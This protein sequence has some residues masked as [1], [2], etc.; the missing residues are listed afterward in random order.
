MTQ[1]PLPASALAENHEADAA[2]DDGVR[3]I[4]PDVAY[5]QLAIVN[6][7]FYGEAG[8]GD[9]GWVL[10]DAGV[11]GS[12]PAI[13]HAAQARFG[14]SGRPACIVLTHGHFDHVGVL[15]TLSREWDVPV[16]AHPLEHPYLNGTRSYP[17]PDPHVGGGMLARLSPL[18]PTSPVDVGAHLRDLPPDHSVPFMSGFRWIH[19]PG[20][21]P[22]HVSLWRERDRLL[23][24]GDAIVTTA[25]ESVYASVTQAPEMHGPP[26]YFTPDWAAARESVRAIDALSPETVITGHGA[27]MQGQDMKLALAAL[28]RNFDVVA[29][30][31]DK[32][33]GDA[34]EA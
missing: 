33:G 30:P 12:G 22:G 19:T 28:A 3:E 24:A 21:A 4:A 1:I 6:V 7:A 5:R 8:A 2:R 26:M 20:H 31:E 14:G 29:V 18:F 34:S 17:P 10:I 25:Q 16:Y 23:I 11:F 13:R 27:A 15:E 32:R 9:G